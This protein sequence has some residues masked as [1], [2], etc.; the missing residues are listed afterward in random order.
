[1]PALLYT[2]YMFCTGFVDVNCKH[3]GANRVRINPNGLC[4]YAGSIHNTDM[5]MRMFCR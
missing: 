1:M 5:K 2:I 4:V 3:A